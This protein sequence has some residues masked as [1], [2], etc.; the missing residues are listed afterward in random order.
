[1]AE[2]YSY[3][4]SIAYVEKTNFNNKEE[5]ED[6]SQWMGKRMNFKTASF[7]FPINM[8]NQSDMRPSDFPES[9]SKYKERFQKEKGMSK[10]VSKPKS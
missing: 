10:E 5:R 7:N 1:M 3:S 6:F 4:Q 9:V 2:G 8:S